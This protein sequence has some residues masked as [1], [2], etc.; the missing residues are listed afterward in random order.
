MMMAILLL[1]RD[2]KLREIWKLRS[3]VILC[4]ESGK[5][6]MMIYFNQRKS[7]LFKIQKDRIVKFKGIFLIINFKKW[8][9]YHSLKNLKNNGLNLGLNNIN[10]LN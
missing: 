1:K 3:S 2:R 7:L 8:R 9:Y 6:V 5:N 10:L 4:W